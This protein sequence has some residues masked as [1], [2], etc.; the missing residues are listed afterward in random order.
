[1]RCGWDPREYIEFLPIDKAFYWCGVVVLPKQHEVT[2][3]LANLHVKQAY[4]G[5]TR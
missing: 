4:Y 2:L 1:M 5:I 3:V